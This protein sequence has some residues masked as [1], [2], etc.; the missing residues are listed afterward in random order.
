MSYTIH[1]T[2]KLLAR[3]KQPVLDP[4]EVPSTMLGNRYANSLMWR[5]QVALFVNEATLLPVFVPLA[6]AKDVA[7][8]FPEQ[9]GFVLGA[10]GVPVDFVAQEVLS[11]GDAVFAKTASRSVLGSMNDFAYLAGFHREAGLAE[12]LVALSASMAQTPCS[13]LYP[14]HGSPDR[15]V[16]ALVSDWS[17]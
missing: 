17:A 12:D 15:E 1:A 6:P 7:D 9:L 13:P 16:R 11:M 3:V 2:R 5:P 8:R 4:V 14:C 10:I